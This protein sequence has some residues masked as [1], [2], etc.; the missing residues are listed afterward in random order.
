MSATECGRPHTTYETVSLLPSVA[1]ALRHIMVTSQLYIKH[2]CFWWV[3]YCTLT[4]IIVISDLII[5]G[6]T[7]GQKSTL[8]HT[9]FRVID[10]CSSKF[11]NVLVH[12]QHLT[13]S[14]VVIRTSPGFFHCPDMVRLSERGTESIRC[15][16]HLDEG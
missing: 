10:S 15:A 16:K 3:L 2:C 4:I 5:G 6:C 9:S 11:I 8:Q 1:G 7:N 13:Q 12:H 14:F